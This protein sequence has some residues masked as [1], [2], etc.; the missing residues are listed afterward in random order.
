VGAIAK[1]FVLRL[2]AAAQTNG[3]SS[4]QIEGIPLSIVNRK[5]T[6]DLNGP[7]I[8]DYDFR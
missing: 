5:F 6:F 4:R 3:G 8:V 2:T 7:V 1:R